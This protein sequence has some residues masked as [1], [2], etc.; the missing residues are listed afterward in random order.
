LQDG[1]GGYIP[2]V[3]VLAVNLEKRNSSGYVYTES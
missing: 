3:L 1:D 2:G